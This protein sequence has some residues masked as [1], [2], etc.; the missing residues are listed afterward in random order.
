MTA[1][2]AKPAADIRYWDNL[3]G[4]IV[5]ATSPEVAGFK[6]VLQSEAGGY[7]RDLPISFR[8]PPGG[9]CRMGWVRTR[10]ASDI[11]VTA[12]NSAEVKR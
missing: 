3:P 10:S 7:L 5:Y 8:G 6:A 11:S 2:A 1:N 12:P 4:E 9:T